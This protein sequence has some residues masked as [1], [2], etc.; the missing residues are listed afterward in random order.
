[1]GG[2]SYTSNLENVLLTGDREYFESAQYYREL[3][4]RIC[5]AF[6]EKANRTSRPHRRWFRIDEIEPD[7][8]A[9]RELAE[10]WRK[11]IYSGDL[12]STQNKSQVL[13]FSDTPLLQ[14]FRFPRDLAKG[15][16]FND[17]IQ[18]LWMS[19]PQWRKWLRD[20]EKRIPAW[21]A[22]AGKT[23]KGKRGAKLTENDTAVLAALNKLYPDGDLEGIKANHRNLQ[24]NEWLALYRGR[25]LELRTMQRA[26][27]KIRYY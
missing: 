22:T 23:W 15:E 2:K 12:I 5:A 10:L 8:S 7:E 18:H 11:S 17:I 20:N 3:R 9:R 1:M 6:V 26:L 21:L 19:A 25:Q 24:I 27:Q 13:C 16:H 4:K 14:G